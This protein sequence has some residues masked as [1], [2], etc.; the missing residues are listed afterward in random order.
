MLMVASIYQSV[1]QNFSWQLHYG[2]A[3]LF[4][5]KNQ[6]TVGQESERGILIPLKQKLNTLWTIATASF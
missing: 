1:A 3:N 4:F 6:F 5:S 2:A